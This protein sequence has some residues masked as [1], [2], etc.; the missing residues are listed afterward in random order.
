[1]FPLHA[2]LV[3]DLSILLVIAPK[4]VEDAAKQVGV[5][6]SSLMRQEES[7]S[8]NPVQFHNTLVLLDRSN[9][10]FIKAARASIQGS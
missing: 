6:I 10:A 1:L 9:R 2:K 5:G 3:S 4:P 7:K 8:F